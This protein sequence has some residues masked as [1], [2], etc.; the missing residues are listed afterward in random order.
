MDED[1][2]RELG[3]LLSVLRRRAG[4]SQR[5]LG[6]LV[7]YDHS[8]VGHAER[9]KPCGAEAFWRLC[10]DLLDAD[11]VLIEGYV[12]VR[13]AEIAAQERMRRQQQEARQQQAIGLLTGRCERV[14]GP[15][16]TAMCPRC[17]QPF[18]LIPIGISDT[19]E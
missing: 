1:G 3:L 12:Q 8:V 2:R 6:R 7:S 19:T 13:H 11:G 9:G 4:L 10:D 15:V 17:H 5:Q 16:A 18:E 14:A